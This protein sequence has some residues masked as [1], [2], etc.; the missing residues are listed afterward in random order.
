MDRRFAEVFQT[1]FFTHLMISNEKLR[2][3]FSQPGPSGDHCRLRKSL[4]D[5]NE[6][7]TS[8]AA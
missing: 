2:G 6:L 7:S 8:V 4:F 3:V 1:N 5:S